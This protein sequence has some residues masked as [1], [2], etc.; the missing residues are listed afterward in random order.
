MLS[1]HKRESRLASTSIPR[2]QLACDKQEYLAKWNDRKDKRT[3]QLSAISTADKLSGYVFGMEIN[4]Y[5]STTPEDIVR[6]NEYFNDLKLH[7]PFKSHAR[8]WTPDEIPT[9]SVTTGEDDQR[10]SSLVDLHLSQHLI[11]RDRSVD[12]M[13]QE[14]QIPLKGVQV[15]SKYT[16]HDHRTGLAYQLRNVGR[17][18]I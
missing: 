15:H 17:I 8:V 1:A 13:F 5:A 14:N 2:M 4:Y 6:D 9:L 12:E 10:L 16:R 11:D 3:T 7:F 18:S